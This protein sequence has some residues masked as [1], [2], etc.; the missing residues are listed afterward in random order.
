MMLSSGYVPVSVDTRRNADE[1]HICL[2]LEMK[3]GTGADCL[4][5]R[6]VMLSTAARRPSE[7]DL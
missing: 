4:D 6:A 7:N 2:R 3:P 1:N 5:D